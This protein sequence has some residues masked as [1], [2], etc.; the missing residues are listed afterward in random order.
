MT[1]RKIQLTMDKALQPAKK[2]EAVKDKRPSSKKPLAKKPSTESKEPA[3][4]P[5]EPAKEQ[6]K[7]E[8]VRR[9]YSVA[10]KPVHRNQMDALAKKY[11]QIGHFRPGT[12]HH[13][14]TYLFE[15]SREEAMEIVHKP[16]VVC[17]ETL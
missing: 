11:K 16:F 7:P 8:V 15:L 13:Y 1:I 6:A 12:L 10:F 14:Q 5:S 9:T 17:I 2:N 3:T 4:S